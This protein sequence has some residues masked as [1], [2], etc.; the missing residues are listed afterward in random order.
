MPIPATTSADVLLRTLLIRQVDDLDYWI[1][2]ED[3]TP[4]LPQVDLHRS[5]ANRPCP[6]SVEKD[7]E[8]LERHQL[9]SFRRDNPHVRLTPLGVYTALLF[10]LVPEEP[11]CNAPA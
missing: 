4:E 8:F 6:R 11:E 2:V 3:I 1:S 10:S 7:I 5:D 9:V